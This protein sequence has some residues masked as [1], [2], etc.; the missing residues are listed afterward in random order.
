MEELPHKIQ[1]S[2]WHW[3]SGRHPGSPCSH[4]K[5]MA[6][7]HFSLGVDNLF[8]LVWVPLSVIFSLFSDLMCL[9]SQRR[10]GLLF[11]WF[12][13]PEER[14]DFLVCSFVVVV[15]LSFMVVLRVFFV[16]VGGWSFLPLPLSLRDGGFSLLFGGGVVVVVLAFLVVLHVLFFSFSKYIYNNHF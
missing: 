4:Y 8:D 10:L 2:M 6:G 12:W 7:N 3:F 15:V 11:I 9:I 16:F 13:S 5:W 14:E 1:F